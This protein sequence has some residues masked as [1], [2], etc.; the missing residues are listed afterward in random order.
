MTKHI[1]CNYK[2]KFN[3]ATC[4]SNQEWNNGTCQCECKNYHKC[5]EDY[6]WN[7]STCIF[8]NSN[9]LKSV[10]DTSL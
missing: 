4:D 10:V 5:R 7:P 6:S 8:G 1:S 2:C 9:Y 3:R